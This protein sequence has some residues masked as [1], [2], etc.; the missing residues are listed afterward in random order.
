MRN[1]QAEVSR[2]IQRG[3]IIQT[4]KTKLKH[5]GGRQLVSFGPYIQAVGPKLY[6]VLTK[7][8]VITSLSAITAAKNF[9]EFVGRERAWPALIHSYAKKG[10]RSE[11]D[12]LHRSGY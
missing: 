7:N 11:V 3:L 2:A 6:A 5:E 4:Q 8:E 10:L 9:V 12:R 1:V